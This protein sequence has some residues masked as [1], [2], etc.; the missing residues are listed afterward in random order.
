MNVKE[1]RL[2]DMLERVSA[3][4]ATHGKD[5]FPAGTVG[6]HLFAAVGSAA[7]DAQRHAGDR[8]RGSDVAASKAD[9]PTTL[10]RALD[11]I[12]RTARAF[13][14]DHPCLEQRFRL[15]RGSGNLPLLHASRAIAT[16]ARESAAAFIALGLPPTFLDDL[17]G[18]IEGFER[19]MSDHRSSRVNRKSARVALQA[20]LK[21]G[22][23]AVRRL[24]AVVP[25][26]L[27]PDSAM[28]AAWR[29]AR[30]VKR[31]RQRGHVA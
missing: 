23:T 22:F 17:A 15:P 12:R 20:S 14:L 16:G 10:W 6:D 11:A 7:R 2:F 30:R 28:L 13:A 18:R 25:N 3:F 5:C 29:K 19:A 24:D 27:G 31:V 9:A 4:G 26:V 1:G 8:A 21:A